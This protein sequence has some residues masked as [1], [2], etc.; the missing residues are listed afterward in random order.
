MVRTT[1]AKR[2]PAGVPSS[3]PAPTENGKL[4]MKTASGADPV[5]HRKSTPRRLSEPPFSFSTSS[6]SLM[7]TEVIIPSWCMWGWGCPPPSVLAMRTSRC[8][9]HCRAACSD[10]APHAQATDHPA[11]EAICPE[12]IAECDD[13]H[14]NAVALWVGRFGLGERLD[15]HALHDLAP[16]AEPHI[17]LVGQDEPAADVRVPALR[18]AVERPD[19]VHHH[20]VA[21]GAHE[22]ADP[23]SGPAL[24]G[25]HLLAHTLPVGVLEEAARDPAVAPATRRHGLLTVVDPAQRQLQERPPTL[26]TGQ[27]AQLSAKLTF[28]GR[29]G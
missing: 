24:V 17:D 29:H 22:R 16:L 11:S 18:E 20:S 6:R 26:G 19:G 2:K 15:Q 14:E 10:P 7:S 25:E 5:T 8:R 28:L 9:W 13:L 3:L 12:R 1:V 23:V 27:P 21:A 4:N